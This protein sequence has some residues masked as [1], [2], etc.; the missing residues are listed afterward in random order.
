MEVGQGP[1]WGCSAKGKKSAGMVTSLQA[2]R[3]ENRGS[4]SSRWGDFLFSTRPGPTL[5]YSQTSYQRESFFGD[6]ATEA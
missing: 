6:K 5:E 3:P 4:I 1:N 2:V